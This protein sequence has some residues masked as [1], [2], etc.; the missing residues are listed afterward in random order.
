MKRNTCE[1]LSKSI[2]GTFAGTLSHASFFLLDGTFETTIKSEK[3]E[4]IGF[5][6]WFHENVLS[7]YQLDIVF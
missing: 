4:Y 7:P 3:W 5:I 1:I 2:L 6:M